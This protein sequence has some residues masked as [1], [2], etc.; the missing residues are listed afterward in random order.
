MRPFPKIHNYQNSI[1]NTNNEMNLSVM[2]FCFI[3][4]P[5]EESDVSVTYQQVTTVFV[6][7]HEIC[8]DLVM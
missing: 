3:M 2:S 5:M 1:Y 7:L 6:H 8:F 4:L